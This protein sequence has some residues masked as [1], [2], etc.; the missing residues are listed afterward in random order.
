MTCP[1]CGSACERDEI[2]VGGMSVPAG[3]WGCPECHWVEVDVEELEGDGIGI[4]A[5]DDDAD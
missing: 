2:D 4:R 1:Q 3:L 5:V